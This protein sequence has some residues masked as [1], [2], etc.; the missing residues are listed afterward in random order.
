METPSQ[1]IIGK[2]TITQRHHILV[3][4]EAMLQNARMDR[5]P[6]G[7]DIFPELALYLA[8]LLGHHS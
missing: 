8:N 7:L 5:K 1:L 4:G 3:Q 6:R 2:S